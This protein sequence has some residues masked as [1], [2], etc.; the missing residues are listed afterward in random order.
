MIYIRQATKADFEQIWLIIRSV[1]IR[2]DTFVFE[3]DTPKEEMEKYWMDESGL[4]FVAEDIK[5]TIVGTYM[6]KPNQPGLGSHVA[7]A[8]FMVQPEKHSLGIGK[9]MGEH[10]LLEAK[11]AGFLAMQFN[12]V[13]S[14]NT[15][16]VAL[17]QKLG[18]SII[19]R[20]PKVFRHQQEGLIDAFVMHKLL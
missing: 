15:N 11:K 2:G 17:W 19:G 16:A 20:L 13:I 14:T 3:P 8:S 4:T 7:N 9:S 6:I 18:F 10:A 1:I 5:S 12:M